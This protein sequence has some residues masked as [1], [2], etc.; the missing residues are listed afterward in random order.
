MARVFRGVAAALMLCASGARAHDTLS[1]DP[2]AKPEF[3]MDPNTMIGG[4]PAP[5][6]IQ[7]MATVRLRPSDLEIDLTVAD[8]AAYKL[9]DHDPFQAPISSATAEASTPTVNDSS[10]LPIVHDPHFD[11]DKPLLAQRGETLFLITSNGAKLAPLA[12]AVD[13]SDT[14]DVT[15]HI[16]YPKPPPGPLHMEMTY[17]NQVPA[18]Q[19]DIVTVLDAAEKTLASASLSASTPYMDVPVD[20]PGAAPSA[21]AA[22]PPN[23]PLKPSPFAFIAG[24]LAGIAAMFAVF[25]FLRRPE[26]R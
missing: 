10:G 17:F 18:G 12:A 11:Q 13:L 1:F 8:G 5:V 4:P 9:L 23:S 16:T 6:V 2:N 22:P 24:V 21:M 7:G 20:A 15:F 26:T 25:K 19:K 3:A 14:H